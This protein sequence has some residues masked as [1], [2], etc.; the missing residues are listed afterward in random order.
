MTLG[1]AVGRA[2]VEYDAVD[3]VWSLTLEPDGESAATRAFAS[4]RDAVSFALS[5]ERILQFFRWSAADKLFVAMSRTEWS[6][7]VNDSNPS[8]D[9]PS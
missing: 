2:W 1:P 3:C 9:P 7:L 6:D 5:D 4:L 8:T